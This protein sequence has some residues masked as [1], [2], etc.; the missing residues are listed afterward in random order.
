VTTSRE[1]L[2]LGTGAL[3]VILAFVTLATFTRPPLEAPIEFAR[4]GLPPRDGDTRPGADANEEAEEQ[5]ESV[6]SASRPGRRRSGLERPAR[7]DP[8]RS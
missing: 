2:G 7:P 1:R 8:G 6:R 3:I 5:A 4:A